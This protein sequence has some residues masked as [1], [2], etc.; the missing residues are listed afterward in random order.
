MFPLSGNGERFPAEHQYGASIAGE[1]AAYRMTA[2]LSLAGLV[3]F[4]QSPQYNDLLL[5]LSLKLSF[6]P[7]AALFSADLPI[8]ATLIGPSER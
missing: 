6:S 3:R 5:G 2:Q 8:A 4:R 1:L 7:R